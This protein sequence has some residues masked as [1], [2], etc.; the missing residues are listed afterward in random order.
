M[1]A[2]VIRLGSPKLWI[3]L[4]LM[5]APPMYACASGETGEGPEG[6]TTGPLDAG[7]DR[8]KD[9]TNGSDGGEDGSSDGDAGCSKTSQ[10]CTSAQCPPTA[11]VETTT[12]TN[13]VC[14]I[15]TCSAGWYD[16]DASYA[17]GCNCE[18]ST[19]GTSCAT[20]TVVPPLALGGS[21]MLSGNIPTESTENWFQIT[22]GGAAT[23][24]SYHPEIQFMTNPENEFVFE[25]VSACSGAPLSCADLD[26]ATSVTTWEE[27]YTPQD[28]APPAYPS[29]FMPISPVGAAGV[30]LIRV[31]RANP[32]ANC[33]GYE[34]TV[35]D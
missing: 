13:G 17:K 2:P 27:F 30:V 14:G 25:V 21:T 32:G 4:A 7:G 15:S 9:A 35:S 23:N 29:E 8:H 3:A 1:G 18:A 33:D 20:A 22:F 16:Y 26:A 11:H 28:A 34:L 19:N 5:L 6:G 24:L 10:C 31:H 12:C